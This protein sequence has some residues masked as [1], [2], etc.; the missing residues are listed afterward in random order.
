MYFQLTT[1]VE[2]SRTNLS[3]GD[4]DDLDRGQGSVTAVSLGVVDGV[5]NIHAGRHLAEHNVLGRSGAVKEVKERVVLGVDEE[6][7]STGARLASVG[8]GQSADFVTELGAV[9]LLEL[10]RDGTTAVTGDGA[11]A[12]NLVLGVR[13]RSAST[14]SARVGVTRVGAAELVHEVGDHTVEVKA[15]VEARVGKVNEVVCLRRVEKVNKV[16]N[17]SAA[18]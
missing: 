2:A 11:L 6:L 12:R 4:F 16:V 3:D 8:H 5:H 1:N 18:L 17:R 9:R 10:I 7:G 14:G 15:I 13:G